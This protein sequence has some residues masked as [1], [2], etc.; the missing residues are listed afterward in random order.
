MLSTRS[1]SILSITSADQHRM[2][3]PTKCSIK[4][5]VLQSL[6]VTEPEKLISCPRRRRLSVFSFVEQI[7]VLSS[8]H[9]VVRFR[10]VYLWSISSGQR[11]RL[12]D[13]SSVLT[14]VKSR[15]PM[16]AGSRWGRRNHF[17]SK[18]CASYPQ[19]LSPLTRERFSLK[20]TLGSILQ[21]NICHNANSVAPFSEIIC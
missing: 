3:F 21:Y 7:R 15:C 18:F 13:I 17:H 2:L 5:A 9:K 19:T 14:C 8:V 6:L 4:S 10:S 16:I 1:S 20:T 11:D 12:K